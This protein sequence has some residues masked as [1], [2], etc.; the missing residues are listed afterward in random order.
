MYRIY[1]DALPKV[2]R[3]VFSILK[4]IPLWDDF[5]LAGGSGLALQIRHRLSM[6]FDLFSNSNKLDESERK[7]LQKTLLNYGSTT[8]KTSKYETL[9][10]VFNGVIISFFHYDYPLIKRLREF[11][12]INIASITDIGLMKLAAIIGRGSKKDFFD[13]YFIL[14][15]HIGF[16]KLLLLSKKKFVEVP[17]FDIQAMRALVYFDDAESER[18]PEMIIKVSWNEVKDFLREE[19]K[20]LNEQWI[21]Q[22]KS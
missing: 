19:V 8:I 11:N 14:K 18:T 12:S 9:E 6:D 3:N 10:V 17:S 2:S 5:Y 21:M 20:L 4:N 22:K 15:E 7:N 16:E 1:I 13:I